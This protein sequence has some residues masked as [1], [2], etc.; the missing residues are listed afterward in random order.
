MA[1]G[2]GVGPPPCLRWTCAGLTPRL[3]PVFPIVRRGTPFPGILQRAIPSAENPIP[4]IL[5]C[6]DADFL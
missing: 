5:N 3:T 4:S 2:Q 6:S 1:A